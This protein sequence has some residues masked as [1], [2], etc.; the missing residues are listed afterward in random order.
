MTE[1]RNIFEF[2]DGTKDREVDPLEVGSVLEAE[3][4]EYLE[5]A[6]T[7]VSEP[8]IKLP[9]GGLTESVGNQKVEANQKLLAV[10]RKMFG[11]KP[12]SSVDGK[13]SGLTQEET[14]AL[15][16]S[17]MKFMGGLADEARPF[18]SSPPPGTPSTSSDS[19]TESSVDYGTP[20]E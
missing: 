9:P 14:L 18:V 20:G 15:L 11:V 6:E 13:R 17:F 8:A 19:T 4:P 3:C 7:L 2:H 12:F 16:A 10:T 1:D 5:L